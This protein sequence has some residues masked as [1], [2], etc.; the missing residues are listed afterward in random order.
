M[1]TSA[2]KPAPAAQP[3]L[4]SQRLGAGL[5]Y[6]IEA[7][8]CLLAFGS[9]WAFGGIEQF[10]YFLYFGIA[11][12][13]ALWALRLIV[14]R[15]FWWRRCPIALGLAALFLWGALQLAPL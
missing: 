14:E 1:A 8:M 3:R 9:P 15:R 2:E 6:A 11:L 7:L 5:G 12:M 4:A 13:L 10:E